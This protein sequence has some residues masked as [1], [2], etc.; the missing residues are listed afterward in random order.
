MNKLLFCPL[1]FLPVFGFSISTARAY[2]AI[3]VSAASTY[4]AHIEVFGYSHF[5]A[6][7]QN[8]V[9]KRALENC[10]LAGG[11]DPK[12]VASTSKSGYSAVVA[13]KNGKERILGWAVAMSSKDAAEKKAIEE[14]RKRGGTDPRVRASWV[15]RGTGWKEN[16]S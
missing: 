14:C 10:T 13:S 2:S 6:Q 4:G 1:I 8:V 3:A 7:P 12:I 11:T 16:K 5:P 15:D 9:E